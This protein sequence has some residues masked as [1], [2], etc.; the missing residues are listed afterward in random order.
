MGFLNSISSAFR[1]HFDKKKEERE[2]MERVQKEAEIQR[3]EV[4][5]ENLR[6]NSLEVAKA[7]ALKDAAE[8]SGLQRLR[9]INRAKNL[10]SS[11]APPGSFFEKLG[12]YTQK[13]L[14]RRE[15]N[16]AKTEALRKA[17]QEMKEDR[18]KQIQHRNLAR[19]PAWGPSKWKP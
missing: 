4:F 6:K 16:L 19:K 14:A 8:K 10:A 11:Q 9:Q 1:D 12:G 5:E 3:L 17:A 13:N 18:Q 7:K 15:A 2:I